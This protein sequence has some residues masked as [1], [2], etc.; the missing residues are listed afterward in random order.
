MK[1][2]DCPRPRAILIGAVILSQFSFTAL[3]QSRADSGNGEHWMATWVTAPQSPRPAPIRATQ[4]ATAPPNNAPAPIV[5]FHDQTVRMIV[6]TSI[7]GPRARVQLS[8]IYSTS[9]LKI[10]SAHLAIRS[11]DS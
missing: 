9:A 2:H 1:V 4:S 3:A 5:S 8:N 6:H 7:G 11:K 10:G